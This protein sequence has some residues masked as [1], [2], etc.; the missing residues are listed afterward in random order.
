LG[1]S[2]RRPLTLSRKKCRS[3]YF[4]CR[5]AVVASRIVSMALSGVYADDVPATTREVRD[6]VSIHSC[7]HRKSTMSL[8][9]AFM[10]VLGPNHHFTRRSFATFTEWRSSAYTGLSRHADYLSGPVT[11]SNIYPRLMRGFTPTLAYSLAAGFRGCLSDQNWLRQSPSWNLLMSIL[12][13]KTRSPINLW[14]W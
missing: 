5:L 4:T 13:S 2:G 6:E 1:H 11:K 9:P 8:S 3:R 14:G 7:V 12:T 10:R